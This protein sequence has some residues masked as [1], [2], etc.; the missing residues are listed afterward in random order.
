MVLMRNSFTVLFIK[1]GR[2]LFNEEEF[3]MMWTRLV[4]LRRFQWQLF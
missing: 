3:A 2:N 4:D 1:L